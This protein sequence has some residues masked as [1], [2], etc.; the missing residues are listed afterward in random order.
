MGGSPVADVNVFADLGSIALDWVGLKSL[1]PMKRML[2]GRA[3]LTNKLII[4]LVRSPLLPPSLLKQFARIGELKIV[5]IGSK[6]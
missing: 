6:T 3:S 4:T 1:I 5:C 2:P